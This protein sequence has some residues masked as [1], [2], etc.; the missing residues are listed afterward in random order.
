MT[1]ISV[2]PTGIG[3]DGSFSG[4][5][6]YIEWNSVSFGVFNGLD[7]NAFFRFD[8]V[9]IPPGVEITAAKITLTAYGNTAVDD[10]NVLIKCVEASD[11]IAPTNY[12][13]WTALSW[14]ST[15]VAWNTVVAFV[16]GTQYDTPSLIA[17]F[18]EV[19][20]GPFWA[21]GDAIIVGFFNNSS[22][23]N[24]FR[25]ASA[26]DWDGGGGVGD[27]KPELHLSYT[28]NVYYSE[29]DDG[30]D[31]EEEVVDY[32]FLAVSESLG[33]TEEATPAILAEADDTLGITETASQ[34]LDL[35]LADTLGISGTQVAVGKWYIKSLAET[36]HATEKAS[37]QWMISIAETLG[38]TDAVTPA[39]VI[40]IYDTIVARDALSSFWTGMGSISDT[41]GAKDAATLIRIYI[42]SIIDTL[43]VTEAAT[44][45][46]ILIVADY[47]LVRETLS[48]QAV[49]NKEL[50][51][52]LEATDAAVAQ[53]MLTALETLG[54]TDAVTLSLIVA[55]ADSLGITDALSS[56]GTFGLSA[57]DQLQLIDT[58]SA[59]YGLSIADTLGATDAAS[60]IAS[61]YAAISDSAGIAEAA[62][63]ALELYLSLADTAAVIDTASSTGVLYLTIEEAVHLSVIVE[64]DNEIYECF[65]LNT[66]TF[67]PS[68]YSGFDF[69]SYCS[70]KNR[71]FAARPATGIFEL[72][73]DDDAGSEIGTGVLLQNTDLGTRAKK[74]IRKAY[75][76][77]SGDAPIM[78]MEEVDG[79]TRRA[80]AIDSKGVAPGSRDV[81]GKVWQM[82]VVD[83]DELE[84]VQLVPV[85]LAKGR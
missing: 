13:T 64:I 81:S 17:I 16:D 46:L 30:A 82:S 40:A 74:R 12:S 55:L 71:A 75:L 59:G 21:S 43:G 66:P 37:A 19:V 78:V 79:G 1:D 85:V 4:E 54:A 20:M 70:Y 8:N 84:T 51:D 6:P 18:Q 7:Q 60:G 47:I 67:L 52:S 38:A 61:L 65:V 77:I 24:A 56:L 49:F 9:V 32:F 41:L 45:A 76:G 68:V 69:D 25:N 72:T 14:F 29:V 48:P 35:V 73:G 3:E 23:T 15:S 44:P 10:V 50:A 58:A 80:Y 31:L 57:A 27:E 62:S 11:P 36:L 22:D 63:A 2:Y 33:I 53:W 42:C 34:S 39:L 5:T 83:F 28:P 26:Y